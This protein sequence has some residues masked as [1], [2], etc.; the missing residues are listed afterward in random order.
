VPAG[1]G[2]PSVA[3]W[4]G[5]RRWRFLP[6]NEA[7]PRS[8]HFPVRRAADR[9]PPPGTKRSESGSMATSVWSVVP[10][11]ATY[12]AA[13]LAPPWGASFLRS[14]PIA[15]R[16]ARASRSK[17][18]IVSMAGRCRALQ[19]IGSHQILQRA[20]GHPRRVAQGSLGLVRH[21][22]PEAENRSCLSGGEYQDSLTRC[23][24]GIQARPAFAS[25]RL[26]RAI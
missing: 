17:G 24:G 22:V 15:F 16:G 14:G 26:D 2:R 8:G 11:A 5:R 25:A 23:L 3:Q 7:L 4:T 19:P 12:A 6:V 21:H 1:G 20:L 10:A 18:T 9:C 13:L